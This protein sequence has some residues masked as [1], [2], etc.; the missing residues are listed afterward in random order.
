MKLK[1][2]KLPGI[3]DLFHF[4]L[5]LSMYGC[6]E[7]LGI[8]GLPGDFFKVIFTVLSLISVP[9]A[10]ARKRGRLL[11]FLDA[12]TKYMYLLYGGVFFTYF[13]P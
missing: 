10:I 12:R 11:R 5:D 7:E 1:P 9:G 6:S 13:R 3:N 8:G 2:I 4:R